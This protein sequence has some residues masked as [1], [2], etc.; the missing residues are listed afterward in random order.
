MSESKLKI[1]I[2]VGTTCY[3]LGASELQSLENFIPEK[4]R[5]KVDICGVTCLELCKNENYG[6]APFVRI[7]EQDI[8][9]NATINKVVEE[10]KK[11]LE[12]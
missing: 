6:K 12:K 5:S 8:I 9:T 2:C 1:E 3:L 11:R 10:I 4:L 7:N